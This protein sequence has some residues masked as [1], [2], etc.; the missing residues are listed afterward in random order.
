MLGGSPSS[1]FFSAHVGEVPPSE[2][3]ISDLMGYLLRRELL[4]RDDMRP[5]LGLGLF[6]Q[7]LR[8]LEV[9]P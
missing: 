4:G 5:I 2:Y 8:R 9:V 3:S 6:H 1:S 7:V